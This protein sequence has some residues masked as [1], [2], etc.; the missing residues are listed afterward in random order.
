MK[1][2]WFV[3]IDVSKLT[4]DVAYCDETSK[5]QKSNY[6]QVK[7][8]ESGFKSLLEWFKTNKIRRS[9]CVIGM[10]HTGIYSMDIAL[11][12]EEKGYDYCMFNPLALKHSFGL[13]RGKND[14][15]DAFRIASY[16]ADHRSKL[17][18][19]RFDKSIIIKLKDLM[20]E[21]KLY[22]TQMAS[23]K[24]ILTDHKGRPTTTRDQRCEQTINMLSKQIKSIENEIMEVIKTDASVLNNY[25]L[26]TS[27][28]GISLVN[29]LNFIVHTNNFESFDNAR[30]YA[31]YTGIAPFGD[32]S[33]TSVRKKPHVSSIGAKQVKADLTQAAR[34]A[35]LY[36]AELTAYYIRKTT[37]GKAY[38]CVMNAV[39]F[40]LVE[41][42]FAVVHNQRPFLPLEE[43]ERVQ[44]QN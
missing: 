25:N 4:L 27:V 21:R 28:K 9:S 29:A 22:V 15:I 3:G 14:R 7:N 33:G 35:I 6:I 24:S 5:L 17:T 20:S 30:Q 2:K 10:E 26:I 13:A 40:K 1:K 38:G 31:C 19:Y 8:N 32:S 23:H 41:R 34:S 42:V 18:Y 12:L 36:D 16:C 43:Y 39:K 44:M 37:E 11:F